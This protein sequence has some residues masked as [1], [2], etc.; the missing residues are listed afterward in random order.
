[1]P[2]ATV[3]DIVACDHALDAI[4]AERGIERSRIRLFPM[5]ETARGKKEKIE[6]IMSGCRR[7]GQRQ[8]CAGFPA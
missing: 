6:M 5:I 8:H 2:K 7:R 4:E 3:E 1:V